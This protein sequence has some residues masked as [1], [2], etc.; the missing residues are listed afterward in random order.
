MKKSIVVLLAVIMAIT[1]LFAACSSKTNNKDNTESSSTTKAE[2]LNTVASNEEYVNVTDKNGEN[3]TDKSGNIVTSRV[4][5]STKNNSSGTGTTASNKG[6]QSVTGGNGY[7]VPTNNSQT[8][9]EQAESTTGTDS[10]TTISSQKDKVPKTTDSGTL[11]N[12]SKKDLEIIDDMLAVPY[13]YECSYENS[14]LSNTT[15]AKFKSTFTK[16]A[17]HAA[18]YMAKIDGITGKQSSSPIVLGL[19]KY[20]GQTVVNF[21][22]NCNN[23]VKS[24]GAPISYNSNGDTFT[25]SGTEKSTHK[26]TITRVEYLGNNNY[27]KVTGTV[28]GTSHAS[29]VVAVVQKNRLHTNLGFS[30]KAV[31][32]S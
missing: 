2:G 20:Y 27:Y 21:K 25:I 29:K 28:S 22:S 18:V 31:K 32:W 16:Y 10:W 30:V 7:T 26:V 3:V 19:F 1:A 6:G 24:S 23:A 9:N 11:V 13:A 4:Y 14:E 5:S 12:F 15:S 17:T 8:T